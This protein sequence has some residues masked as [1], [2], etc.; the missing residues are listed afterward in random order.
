MRLSRTPPSSTSKEQE[1]AGR[2]FFLKDNINQAKW[3]MLLFIIPMSSFIVNDYIFFGL[4]L[5]LAGL[6]AIRIFML[7]T[8]LLEIFYIRKTTNPQSYDLSMFLVFTAWLI[9]GGII[10]LSR[11]DNFVA[12]A[13]LTS[14]SIFV[15]FLVVPFRFKYQCIVGTIT[16][17]GEATIVLLTANPPVSAMSWGSAGKRSG[18]F[19]AWEQ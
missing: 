10:N 14:V 18:S 5:Q 12:Q 15:V 8:A 3:G 17:I 11:P 13:I 1:E 9:C 6:A 4:S 16:T 19:W 2:R 7:V